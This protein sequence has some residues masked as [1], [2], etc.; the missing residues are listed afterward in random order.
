MP[1]IPLFPLQILQITQTLQLHFDG[2]HSGLGS[3]RVQPQVYQLL[4]EVRIPPDSQCSA[5]S[6]P[7]EISRLPTRASYLVSRSYTRQ[8]SCPACLPESIFSSDAVKGKTKRGPALPRYRFVDLLLRR[9]TTH[10]GTAGR[11]Q[12]LSTGSGIGKL[13]AAIYTDPTSS[14]HHPNRRSLL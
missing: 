13:S 9:C 6:R 8:R 2:L 10:A 14:L 4:I 3:F 12:A 11:A 7:R 5:S 1:C